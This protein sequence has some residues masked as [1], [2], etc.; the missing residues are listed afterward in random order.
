MARV[1]G[2]M[3]QTQHFISTKLNQNFENDYKTAESRR[4]G[5]MNAANFYSGV[6]FLVKCSF[7]LGHLK[8]K[9]NLELVE[10]FLSSVFHFKR[11]L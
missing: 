9:S 2:I 10:W 4:L 7:C 1:A 6:T 8:K 5:K 3:E 11:Q